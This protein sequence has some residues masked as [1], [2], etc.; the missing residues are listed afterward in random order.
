MSKSKLS[1]K[2]IVGG[3]MIAGVIVILLVVVWL[4]PSA[5]ERDP[6]TL[7]R[8]EGPSAITAILLDRTDS[9]LPTTKSDLEQRIWNLLDEIEENHEISLFAVDPT[10]GGSLD[11]IIEVCSPGDPDNVD[12]LTQSEAIMRRNWQQKFRTP[13]E[14]ELKK[15][16]TNKE[17]KSSPIMESVQSVAIKHFQSTKRRNV[18]RRLI[19]VSDLLQNSDAISFYKAQPN[20]ER[21]RGS[22]QARGL[23]PDLRN[24]EIELWLIQ[25]KQRQQGDGE[26]VL[27]FFRSWLA[28]HGGQVR[29]SVR[30]SGINN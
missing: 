13:L 22:P 20:F 12:H 14:G 19:I 8:S 3:S 17:A 30:T 29:A 4:K 5:V 26:A 15:L 23:N 24:V 25:R 21:F 6:K 28:E 27:Q 7:C 1:K 16:L 9:F 11:P 18:P 2:K 10:H